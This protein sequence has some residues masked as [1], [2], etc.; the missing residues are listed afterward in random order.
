[1]RPVARVR[2]Q[3]D[4]DLEELAEYIAQ[5]NPRVAHRFYDAA[6]AAFQLLAQMPAMGAAC[7]F[8][9]PAAADLRLWPIHAFEKHVIFYRPID[10]GIEVVRVLH[11]S[12]DIAAIFEA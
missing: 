2:P 7:E 5:H 11:A 1:M 12:R 4:A 10:N 8:R 9:N 6:D 3:A